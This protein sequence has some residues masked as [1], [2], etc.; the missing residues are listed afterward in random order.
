MAR[1][2]TCG[3][4]KNSLTTDVEFTAINN[5]S[6]GT[7]VSAV[8]PRT[9]TYCGQVVLGTGDTF[10]WL[11]EFK[12]TAVTGPLFS[13]FAFKYTVLPTSATVIYAMTNAITFATIQGDDPNI[14]LTSTGTLQLFNGAVQIGSDSAALSSG[15]W[16]EIEMKWDNTPAANLKV[17]EARLNQSVFASSSTIAALNTNNRSALFGGNLYFEANATG[18]F[19]FDDI[20]INDATGTAQTTYVGS[21]KVIML[22]PNA[23]G[24]T[25]TFATQTGG[26]AGAANNYTRVNQVTPDDATTFNGSSTLN[27]ND[28]F[29]MDNSGIGA[30]DTVNVVNIDIRF[31]NSTADTTA[32]F[33]TQVKKVASGTISPSASII[34]NSVTWRTNLAAVPKIPPQVLYLDPDSGAWTQSTLDS[35]QVG[36]KIQVAPGTAGRRI[37]VSQIVAIVGYTPAATNNTKGNFFR[38]FR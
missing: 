13:K 33:R 7:T 20:A 30:S 37:D 35:M 15:T 25:N 1:L 6:A 32:A 3:F 29:N 10:G 11:Y 24:D 36:Y 5:G 38:M 8:S 4:E 2:F 14:K 27:E 21:E 17:M 18:T 9:G 19:Q 28:F 22:K 31:R 34:P 23:A 12:S 26:T 16:Y